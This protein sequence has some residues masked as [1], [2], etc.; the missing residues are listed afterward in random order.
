MSSQPRIGILGLSGQ[1]IFM[2]VD[3]FHQKG[4]TIHAKAYYAEPGGKGY[5][6]AIAAARLGAD[7]FYLSSVGNDVYADICEK[8]L[9]KE[10]INHKLV[11]KENS[12]TALATIL[13][14]RNGQNMV[15]VF[16]GASSLLDAGDVIAYEEYIKCCDILLLQL[17][18]PKTALTTVIDLAEK[19][20]IPVILNPAPALKIDFQVYKKLMLIT[21][22]E[23]EAKFI[24]GINSD[25]I[26]FKEFAKAFCDV[27]I[28]NAVI[29]LGGDGCLVIVDGEYTHIPPIDVQVVD[30]TGAGDVFNAALAVKLASGDDLITAASYA[31]IASG[32][33][34][35]GEGV[36]HS[37]P[38]EKDVTLIERRLLKTSLKNG[39]GGNRID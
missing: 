23:Q 17:E 36:L 15:T 4:E 34:V 37:I 26:E 22:N 27:G 39:I 18:I 33:S 16:S 24:L 35:Q 29:T 10:G 20:D 6:Q 9:I 28:Q 13:T 7:V 30:T 1:S 25:N 21:P 11:R 31:I 2:T 8:Q 14:D 3:H 5:N 38:F 12:G 19:Y 32:L